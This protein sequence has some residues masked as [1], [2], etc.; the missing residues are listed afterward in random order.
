MNRIKIIIVDDH[1]LFR[2]GIRTAIETH[3]PDIHI[4]GEAGTGADFFT[5][6]K[7]VTADIVLLDIMLPDASGIEIARQLKAQYPELKILVISSETHTKTIEDM[8]NIGIE[9]FISKLNSD[10]NQLAEAIRAIARGFEYFGKDIADIIK[11]IYI[12]KKKTKEVTSEFS[13]SER[14][15][16]TYCFEGLSAKMIADRLCISPRTVHW[17]KANIF[18]K[19]GINSTLEM[20]QFAVNNGIIKIGG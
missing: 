11:R 20:V 2:L 18:H 5:L 19:L 9:G 1:N 12:A 10:P 4:V 3:H 15:V 7:N 13:D 17:H 8:L 6:L 14:S 16:I